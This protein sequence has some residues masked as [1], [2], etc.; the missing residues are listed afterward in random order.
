MENQTSQNTPDSDQ[1]NAQQ[2]G[3]QIPPKKK[4][5]FTLALL[6]I[7]AGMYAGTYYKIVV[8]GP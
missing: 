2:R 8:Y 7:V 3:V 4:L 6:L 5:F 1:E